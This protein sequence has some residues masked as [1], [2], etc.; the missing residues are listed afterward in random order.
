MC[1][2]VCKF[3][4]IW[5]MAYLYAWILYMHIYMETILCIFTVPYLFSYIEVFHMKN[6]TSAYIHIL[7]VHTRVHTNIWKSAYTKDGFYICETFVY[8][9]TD[10]YIY[11]WKPYFVYPHFHMCVCVH[12]MHI[13][14]IHI[15]YMCNFYI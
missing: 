13:C 11:I 7:Y 6:M 14:G 4:H 9:H 15:L 1:V 12:N 10:I 5:N 2:C 3:V 8:A